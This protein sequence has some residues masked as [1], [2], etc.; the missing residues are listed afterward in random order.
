MPKKPFTPREIQNQRDR[1]MDCASQVISDFGYHQ[2][3]MRNLAK[4]LNMTAS[5]IYNYFSSKEV[6]YLNTRRRGFELLFDHLKESMSS[7][8]IINNSLYRLSTKMIEFGLDHSGYYQLIFRGPKLKFSP[9]ISCDV[10]LMSCADDLACKWQSH[11]EKSLNDNIE[12]YNRLSE[13]QRT[14]VFLL[15]ISGIHGLI[16]NLQ[17]MPLPLFREIEGGMRSNIIK[18]HISKLIKNTKID[19]YM[20]SYSSDIDK[21]HLVSFIRDQ[22]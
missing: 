9:Y 8:W 1:I 10:S 5:N 14:E 19:T 13:A 15:Y 12:R 21:S 18:R 7:T 6:L 4:K 2:L 20:E 11:V 16:D 22:V 17:Y 3:S